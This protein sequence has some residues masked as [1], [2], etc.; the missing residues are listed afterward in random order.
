MSESGNHSQ[1]ADVISSLFQLPVQQLRCYLIDPDSRRVVDVLQDR[2]AEIWTATSAEVWVDIQASHPNEFQS[3]LDQ[4]DLHPLIRENCQD[5][6]RSSRFSSYDSSLHFEIPVFAED[7]VDQYL[8]V[9]CVP[10]MLI[11]IRTTPLPEVDVLLQHLGDQVRLNEG[12]KSALLHA[13]LDA[14]TDRLVQ[15]AGSVRDEIRRLTCTM[16]TQSDSID[17][18]KIV[19]VKR[20]VQDIS[21]IAE[22]Q[23]Y[24]VTALLSVDTAAFSISQQRD[25]FRDA[26]RSYETALRVL[27]RYEARAAELQQQYLASLQGKTE[28]RL[29]TL[30]ILS[31][32]CMPISLI[33]GIFG[34]NFSHMPELQVS[35]GYPATLIAMAGIALA[36]MWY[37]YKRG[38]FG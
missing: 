18:E 5:P 12:T 22:D 28:A 26:V 3:F 23:L 25:Y 8:S 24:C 21:T 30:T 34:M 38:W 29:R 19:A 37:F 17:I 10:R 16:D 15:A 9:V 11:T 6:C 31:A 36:Q 2:L 1:S 7:S 33:A 4:L 32:I 14:L 27:Q 13:L 35:W 20:I